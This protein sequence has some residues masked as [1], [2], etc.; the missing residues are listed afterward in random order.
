VALLLTR[1]Y[2]AK[3]IPRPVDLEFIG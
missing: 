1:A 2:E 3:I